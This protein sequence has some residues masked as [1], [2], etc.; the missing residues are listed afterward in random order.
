MRKHSLN[1]ELKDAK[2]DLVIMNELI[3]EGGKHKVPCLRVQADG[4]NSQWLYSSDDI[5]SFLDTELNK[6]QE[7]Q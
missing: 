2:I 3:R 5:C 7:G 4:H 1:I 6:L